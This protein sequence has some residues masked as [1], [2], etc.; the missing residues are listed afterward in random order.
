MDLMDL[1]PLVILAYVANTYFIEQLLPVCPRSSHWPEPTC[2]NNYQAP[3]PWKS[4]LSCDWMQNTPNYYCIP[5]QDLTGGKISEKKKDP[6]LKL[7]GTFARHLV[8]IEIVATFMHLSC[9][10]LGLPTWPKTMTTPS[11]KK[12]VT[13]TIFL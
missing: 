10:S 4:I 7:Q 11:R 9:I 12:H 13:L 8:I 1:T 5:L 6:R 2:G 3:C